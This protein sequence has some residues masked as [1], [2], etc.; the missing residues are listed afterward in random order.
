MKNI[1][2]AGLI[3]AVLSASLGVV[4]TPAAAQDRDDYYVYDQPYADDSW[5]D[6]GDY[7]DY[8][9]N[10]YSDDGDRICVERQRVWSRFWG[11]Y[12]TRERRFVC[13]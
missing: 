11:H 5:R 4:T 9:Y 3:T 12:V 10:Y 8:D 1:I 2:H 7:R 6:R 13:D